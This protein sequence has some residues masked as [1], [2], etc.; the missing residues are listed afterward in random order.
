MRMFIYVWCVFLQCTVVYGYNS[1]DAKFDVDPTVLKE[2]KTLHSK[3]LKARDRN[4]D[5]ALELVENALELANSI[6]HD[7]L[8]QRIENSKALCLLMAAEYKEARVII[9][10]LIPLYESQNRHHQVGVLRNRLANIDIK[11]GNFERAKENATFAIQKFEPNKYKQLGIS[12]VYLGEIYRNT[13]D[14][15][16]AFEH[17]Q[18]SVEFQESSG[19]NLFINMAL[20]EL[21]RLQW[22][23]EDYEGASKTLERAISLNIEN[24]QFLILPNLYLG[25]IEYIQNN[26]FLSKSYIQK[27]KTLI[28]NTGNTG[29]LAECNL[30]LGKIA[31][32]Q[33]DYAKAES[34]STIS[35]SQAQALTSL[36]QINEANILEGQIAFEQNNFSQCITLSEKT[37]AFAETENDMELRYLAAELL[38]KCYSK[39]NNPT[40]AFKYQSIFQKSK[41]SFDK[42]KN[43]IF[44]KGLT[45]QYNLEKTKAVELFEKEQLISKHKSRVRDLLIL[46]LT[47]GLISLFLFDLQRQKTKLIKQ[48]EE[49]N[50]ALLNADLKLED[51]NKQLLDKN[52][53]LTSYIDNKL[54]LENFTH[55]A[56]NDL[57]APLREQASFIQFLENETALK[58]SKSEQNYINYISRSNADM[59]SLIDDMIEYSYLKSTE[60]TYSEI[61]PLRIIK[62][63]EYINRDI[64][65]KEKATLVINEVPK[66]LIADKY[67]LVLVFRNLIRN[68]LLYKK[69]NTQPHIEIG[70]EL[71]KGKA[72]FWVKDNGKGIS[73]KYIDQVFTLFKRLTN[74]QKAPGNGLGLA[75]VKEVVQ[76]HNGNVWIESEI[77]QGT[78][79]FFSI[80]S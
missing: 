15:E 55:I 60:Y 23:V 65:I 6:K 67:K 78:T 40:E 26:Y 47:L 25:K 41:E 48:L 43:A 54:Q 28:D 24:D 9:E 32:L 20:T 56:S 17:I 45:T 4:V 49:K 19:D 3:A 10:R 69:E 31:L 73:Q 27:A 5:E 38:S 30:Y 21:G 51:L 14:Y 62:E 70:G 64:I 80:P 11:L 34:Y 39:L 36:R 8:I 2:V 76:K 18:T 7:S 66:S 77:D 61:D 33:Q 46:G 1:T 59:Q 71:K 29:H 58:L 57:K 12:N 13:L 63:A 75:M 68:S 52:N 35:K 42:N 16:K 74:N 50:H 72:V 53:N 37:Y 44:I 22:D 79:I